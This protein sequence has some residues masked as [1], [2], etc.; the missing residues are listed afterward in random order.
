MRLDEIILELRDKIV[1]HDERIAA[2][3]EREEAVAVEDKVK[4]AKA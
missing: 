4:A 1:E 3:A 2:L